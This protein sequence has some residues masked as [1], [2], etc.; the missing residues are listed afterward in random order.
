MLA[1]RGYEVQEGVYLVNRTRKM[2]DERTRLSCMW[3]SAAPAPAGFPGTM[4]EWIEANPD[5]AARRVALA[6]DGVVYVGIWRD[7][8]GVTVASVKEDS[9]QSTEAQT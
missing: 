6:H 2:I 4:Q 5:E 3:K 9:C 7:A 1:V 8:E